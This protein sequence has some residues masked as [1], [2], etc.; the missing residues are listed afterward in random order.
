M[1]TKAE[2]QQMDLGANHE[3][4]HETEGLLQKKIWLPKLIYDGLPYFYLTAG[5]AAFFATLYIT[6][7]FWILPHYLLLSAACLHLGFSVRGRRSKAGE[8]KQN[9]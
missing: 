6:E 8:S 3:D 4:S 9:H 2:P 1:L 7:W 5:F